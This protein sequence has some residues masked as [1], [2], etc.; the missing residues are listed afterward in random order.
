VAVTGP[1]RDPDRERRLRE[2]GAWHREWSAKASA[3]PHTGFHPDEHPKRVSDH[4]VH[5]EDLDAP[6]EL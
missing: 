3:D 5:E 1:R 6:P 2:L 4:N